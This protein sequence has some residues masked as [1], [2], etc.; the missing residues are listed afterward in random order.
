VRLRPPNP[1]LRERVAA[2]H[3]TFCRILIAVNKNRAVDG[4]Q[5]RREIERAPDPE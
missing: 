3:A 1:T 5:D 4:S 2:C